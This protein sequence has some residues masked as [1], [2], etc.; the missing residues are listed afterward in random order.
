MLQELLTGTLVE[1]HDMI[2]SR[3]EKVFMIEDIY[4]LEQLLDKK[5][6]NFFHLYDQTIGSLQ[7]YWAHLACIQMKKM[8]ELA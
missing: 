7:S 2:N 8:K 4:K 1:S 5:M 3:L 6:T